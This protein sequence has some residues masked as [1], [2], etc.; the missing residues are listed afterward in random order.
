MKLNVARADL[1]GLL[2]KVMGVVERK[3][4]LPI[5]GNVLIHSEQGRLS[6]TATDL[7]MELIAEA[8]LP[9][10]SEQLA[11]TAPGRKLLDICR[12]LADGCDVGLLV[13]GDKLRLQSG[14]ARFTLA[15]LP[16]DNFPS[17][18]APAV[19][20][21]FVIDGS[22]LRRALEQSMFAMALQD[23][24][25]YLNGLLL[26]VEGTALRAVA[27]DGHRLAYSEQILD[28]PVN[29]QKQVIIPR[30]GVVELHRLLGD[31][32]GEVELTLGGNSLRAVIG[33][34]VFSV[35]L[36]DAKY[37][38][39]RRVIPSDV[40]RVIS[41]DKES[42]KQALARVSVV[43]QEKFKS[44]RFDFT[45][46]TL[47]LSAT[48][49]EQEEASDVVDVDYQGKP[50][51]TAYNGSYIMDALNHCGGESIRFGIADGSTA[52]VI[53]SEGDAASRFVVM[54]L[55]L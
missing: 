47:S 23:V 15:T 28:A 6:L 17:F 45:A 41:V 9:E 26:E 30:K 11:V 8:A 29:A 13:E 48:S 2:Q 7:E 31:W 12:S 10:V 39:Y 22:K 1:L 37:P 14:K 32:S 40:G 44:V 36:V 35:K 3:Q 42:L 55:R 34:T 50:L 46:G 43:C 5:L 18:E 49:P 33:D 21:R 19:E 16:V 24:R 25:F 20:E 4:T 51:E 53:A 27:S 38:D 52:C 54:P